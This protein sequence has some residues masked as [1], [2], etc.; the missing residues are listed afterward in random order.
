[1]PLMIVSNPNGVNLHVQNSQ[2]SATQT[3]CFK[4]QRGKFTRKKAGAAAT[5]PKSFKPQRGKFTLG[6][7]A[8]NKPLNIM[9]QTPTG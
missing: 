3:T 1:M 8:V 7:N 9:F 5:K 2:T 6:R 4:P